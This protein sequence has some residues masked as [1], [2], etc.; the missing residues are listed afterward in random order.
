[1]TKDAIMNRTMKDLCSVIR[2][3]IDKTTAKIT[4][5]PSIVKKSS[6]SK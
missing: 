1:M 2:K 5:N 4:K 3:N 6:K